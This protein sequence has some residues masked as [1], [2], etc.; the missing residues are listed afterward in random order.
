MMQPPSID[1]IRAAKERIRGAVI[2]TPMLVSRTLSEIVGAEVWLKF[3]ISS[4]PQPI[5]SA[6]HSTSFSSFPTR[7]GSVA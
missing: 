6:A 3:G 4:S 7:S 5:K 2:R 1:D